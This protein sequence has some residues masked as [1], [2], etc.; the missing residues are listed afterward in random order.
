MR[1]GFPVSE[2]Q[3]PSR[4]STKPDL[5]I[6]GIIR[7]WPADFPDPKF[8]YVRWCADF[9]IRSQATDRVVGVIARAGREGHLTYREAS[10]RALRTLQ[11]QVSSAVVK[12]LADQIYGDAQEASSPV[13]SVYSNLEWRGR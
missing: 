7:L 8:R 11:Q 9:M 3:M 6:Q 5:V 10:E 4:E 1:E 13:N 2:P 12:N